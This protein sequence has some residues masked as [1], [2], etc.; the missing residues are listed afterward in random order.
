MLKNKTKSN[1]RII[2][3]SIALIT[4]VLF[5]LCDNLIVNEYT[6]YYTYGWRLGLMND[7][8][9]LIPFAAIFIFSVLECKLEHVNRRAYVFGIFML[10]AVQAL[11]IF[12]GDSTSEFSIFT[13]SFLGKVSDITIA[14]LII[15][16]VMLFLIPIANKIML[17]IYS[18]GMISFFG[19]MIIAL[20]T[21]DSLYNRYMHRSMIGIVFSLIVDI[22]FHVALFFFS[23]LLDKGNESN[24]WLC[25]LGTLMYPIFGNMFDDED[26]E[27]FEEIN[28]ESY[29]NNHINRK[30]ESRNRFNMINYY[31]YFSEDALK[32]IDTFEISGENFLLDS[33]ENAVLYFDLKREEGTTTVGGYFTYT[34]LEDQA[35]RT[36]KKKSVLNKTFKD[37]EMPAI[38]DTDIGVESIEEGTFTVKLDTK[39]FNTSE[40]YD[41]VRN[42][43][44]KFMDAIIIIQNTESY[45]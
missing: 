10:Y 29:N 35:A 5:S 25:F 3:S 36:L 22:L 13:C 4:F 31:E 20:L 45:E 26:E 8:F 16:M 38:A 15:R 2:F 17:K 43:M 18:L 24:A 37:I 23:D 32:V 19:I 40:N 41:E 6:S 21:T 44:L 34:F 33:P 27:Y 39:E 28:G 12:F 9:L 30:K 1:L 14:I 42:Y 7:L 11:F